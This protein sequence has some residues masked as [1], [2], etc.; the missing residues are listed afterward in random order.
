MSDKVEQGHCDEAVNRRYERGIQRQEMQGRC[1]ESAISAPPPPQ[2]LPV[3]ALTPSC[4]VD[5]SDD[6][7]DRLDASPSA[8]TCAIK[9]TPY[10]CKKHLHCSPRGLIISNHW[11]C[12]VDECARQHIESTAVP[13]G[14][15]SDRMF[16]AVAV[17]GVAVAAVPCH[18]G[19]HTENSFPFL[20]NIQMNN[21]L[22]QT[23]EGERG[24]AQDAEGPQRAGESR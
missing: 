14:H 22:A 17:Q 2:A 21:Y 3:A 18:I 23:R 9:R 24:Q 13:V 6:D 8:E 20:R 12:A 16:L 10:A 19:Q 15:L 1:K 4:C 7:G 5:S 11:F